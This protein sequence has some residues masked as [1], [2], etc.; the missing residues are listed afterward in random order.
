MFEQIAGWMVAI[1]IITIIIY[2]ILCFVVAGV[3]GKRGRSYAG[4]FLLSFFFSPIIGI[5]VTLL[6]PSNASN[7]EQTQCQSGERRKCPFCAELVASEAKICKHCQKELPQ[8]DPSSAHQTHP[9]ELPTQAVRNVQAA[10]P[11]A[12]S[13]PKSKATIY[14]VVGVLI[15]AVV[16]GV[17]YWGLTQKKAVEASGPAMVSIPG[18]NYEIGKY[19]VTQGEWKAVMGSN[20]GKFSSCG[21]TCPVDSV[22]WNDAQEFIGKLNKR[23]GKQY[24]LSLS[25]KLRNLLDTAPPGITKDAGCGASLNRVLFASKHWGRFGSGKPNTV[26]GDFSFVYVR[27]GK[28]STKKSISQLRQQIT[29]AEKEVIAQLHLMANNEIEWGATGMQVSCEKA[30]VVI[31]KTLKKHVL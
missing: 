23:T 26:L 29:E 3:A 6:M 12:T 7:I 16:E 24:R 31:T 14:A 30:T 2:I 9:S 27:V 25:P 10:I 11:Q 4:F 20:P 13:A 15:S 22:S 21:D 19:E 17:G 8:T 5:I 28:G 1:S 18:K